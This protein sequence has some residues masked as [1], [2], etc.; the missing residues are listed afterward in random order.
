MK[1]GF[2]HSDKILKMSLQQEEYG[3]HLIQEELD[4]KRFGQTILRQVFK[5]EVEVVAE[6]EIRLERVVWAECRHRCDIQRIWG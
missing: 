6:I 3:R 4:D 5:Q 1:H 2:V